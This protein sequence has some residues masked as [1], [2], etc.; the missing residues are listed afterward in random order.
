MGGLG[1]YAR[2]D[3]N[4]KKNALVL[5]FNYFNK[6]CIIFES[7]GIFSQLIRIW[8]RVGGQEN[9]YSFKSVGNYWTIPYTY[10]FLYLFSK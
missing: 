7:Q 8:G 10:N 6:K 4:E 1:R 5:F 9:P 3:L 2:K